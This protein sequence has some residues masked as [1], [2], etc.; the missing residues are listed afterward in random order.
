[1]TGAERNL[2]IQFEKIAKH[3]RENSFRTRKRYR[4]I[5]IQFLR[6]VAVTFHLQNIKNLKEKHVIAYIRKLEGENKAQS[7]IF[8]HLSAIR[9]YFAKIGL[10]KIS[11]NQELFTLSKKLT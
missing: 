6:F 11:S 1:M 9:F 2:V 5:F 10:Q 8:T 4:L 3:V 7:T